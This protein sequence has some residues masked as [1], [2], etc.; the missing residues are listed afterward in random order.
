[1]L[2]PDIVDGPFDVTGSVELIAL[3]RENGVLVAVLHVNSNSI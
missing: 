2:T 1:M 3:F